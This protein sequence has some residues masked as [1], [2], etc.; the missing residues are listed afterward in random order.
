MFS[1]SVSS[2]CSG[3]EA[4]GSTKLFHQL[5]LSLLLSPLTLSLHEQTAPASFPVHLHHLLLRFL[6]QPSPLR[7]Q[8]DGGKHLS[9]VIGLSGTVGITAGARAISRSNPLT[10]QQQ[11]DR[12]GPGAN[13]SGRRPNNMV[14][15]RKS[16]HLEMYRLHITQHNNQSL[17]SDTIQSYKQNKQQTKSTFEIPSLLN[18]PHVVTKRYDLSLL[19]WN[20]KEDI[21]KSASVFFVHIVQGYYCNRI[22]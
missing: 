22:L 11:S 2:P 3:K 17:W 12:Q 7:C 10:S 19:L 4:R 14:S 15:L 18:H 13:C 21:L 16:I 20:I 9:C 1:R 8:S 5:S 6:H